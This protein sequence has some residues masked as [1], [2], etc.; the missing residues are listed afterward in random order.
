MVKEKTAALE[1]AKKAMA[2]AKAK[3]SGRGGSSSRSTLP[4]GWIQGDWMPSA[5]RQ[6]DIDDLVEVYT[7]EDFMAEK[8]ILDVLSQHIGEKLKAMLEQSVDSFHRR[9]GPRRFIPRNHADAHD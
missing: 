2:Q 4:R 8:E 5:I 3:K 6:D 7:M 1:R 9:S